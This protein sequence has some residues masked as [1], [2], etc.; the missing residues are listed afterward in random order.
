MNSKWTCSFLD[1]SMPIVTDD[2]FGVIVLLIVLA[3]FA[4]FGRRNGR[5]ALIAAIAAVAI[6]DPLGSQIIKPLIG[7]PRP[8]HLEMGRLLVG[9]GSGF[10]MPSLH[11][12]NSFG[13]FTAIVYRFGW[14]ASPFYL[15]AFIVAWSRV[16][17]GVHW[18]TDI[19]AGAFFGITIG[20]LTSAVCAK[21]FEKKV[22]ET[23]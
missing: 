14:K 5:I 2:L 12:A 20:L 11:A 16:Y 1:W 19:M 15:I 18:P 8:C 22:D 17:V 13:A 23:T 3:A 4:I 10:S 7:R 6:I 9:C 21:I